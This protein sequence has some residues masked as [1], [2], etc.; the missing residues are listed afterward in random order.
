M[1]IPSL[2]FYYD[3]DGQQLINSDGTTDNVVT[4]AIYTNN[5][6]VLKIQ[7]YNTYPNV[8]DVSGIVTWKA[9]I[10]NLGGT[11]APFIEA[12]NA[13]FNNDAWANTALGKISI[14]IDSN[15]TTMEADLGS[16]ILKIYYL[17]CKG[18]D[19]ANDITI[20]LSKI[21]GKSTVYNVA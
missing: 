4:P 18:N 21:Y 14:D 9:G 10:G 3:L 17:E 13:D 19:G 8:F 11:A 2:T 5:N 15:S 7:L 1:S 6:Y 12:V 16:K 20:S